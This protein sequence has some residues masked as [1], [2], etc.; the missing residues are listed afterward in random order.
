[1]DEEGHIKQ[2]EPPGSTGQDFPLSERSWFR[3]Q[4][5]RQRSLPQSIAT[6]ARQRLS[7]SSTERTPAHDRYESATA[8]SSRASSVPFREQSKRFVGEYLFSRW[9]GF[10][11]EWERRYQESVRQSNG[12]VMKAMSVLVVIHFLFIVLNVYAVSES[13][14]RNSTF[15]VVSIFAVLLPVSLTL[16]FLSWRRKPFPGWL[17][18]PV[19]AING[20]AWSFIVV[21]RSLACRTGSRDPRLCRNFTQFTS[22]F[23]LYGTIGPLFMLT[24][25]RLNRAVFLGFMTVFMTCNIII[26]SNTI[27]TTWQTLVY[28]FGFYIWVSLMSYWAERV[29]RDNFYLRQELKDQIEA[30][31]QAKGG[32]IREAASKKRFISYIFHELRVPFN[33]AVL[34]LHNLEDEGA[35]TNLESGQISVLEAIKSSFSMMETVLNDV[36]DFQKMEEGR[37]ELQARPF[38]IASAVQSAAYAFASTAQ[39]KNIILMTSVD[40]R[41]VACGGSQ[42]LGDDLRFRQVLNNLVSNALKFT[43]RD[44]RVE[45][46]TTL[47]QAHAKSLNSDNVNVESITIRTAVKDTGVGIAEDDLPKM[48]QPYTQISPWKTQGGKGTGLGLAICKHIIQLAGGTCGV[49]SLVDAGSTFWFEVTFPITSAPPI[50]RSVTQPDLGSLYANSKGTARPAL[51]GTHII[52]ETG[53]PAT[54]GQITALNGKLTPGASIPAGRSHMRSLRVLIV[55]DDKITRMLMSRLL[56][57]LGHRHEIAVDGQEAIDILTRTNG[58]N[59]IV[60]DHLNGMG[61]L[62]FDPMSTDTLQNTLDHPRSTDG[63]LGNCSMTSSSSRDS[64]KPDKADHIEINVDNLLSQKIKP[65]NSSSSAS[66]SPPPPVMSMISKTITKS[67]LLNSPSTFRAASH[68]TQSTPTTLLRPSTGSTLPSTSGHPSTSPAPEPFDVVLMDN[69][70]PRKTGVEAVAFLRRQGVLVP[71]VGITGNALK[72]DQDQFLQAGADLVITKPLA[73]A[74]LISALQLIP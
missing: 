53:S 40:P 30:T 46:A 25:Y 41:I 57:Q 20:W 28:I 31:R 21:T 19:V 1:M 2:F 73:K 66:P 72:E 18:H 63:F 42:L 26:S 32:E 60:N 4:Q 71:V 69:H 15:T 34:G 56:Q 49:D 47:I 45:I 12:P 23:V 24:I 17:Y 7:R 44:G 35:F 62:R 51:V 9:P 11:H 29:D 67:A 70:M 38:D 6:F 3:R 64:A 33:T 59:G 65:C 37:F 74:K 14:E 50:S 68:T 43:P 5:T 55:D 48:F 16:P 39:D 36:L 8:S 58:S 13:S 22:A 52:K 61:M 10:D 27:R 54:D